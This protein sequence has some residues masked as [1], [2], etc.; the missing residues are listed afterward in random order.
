MKAALMAEFIVSIERRIIHEVRVTADS[1]AKARAEV[2]GYG[3]QEAW[4]D[5]PCAQESEVIRITGV[6]RA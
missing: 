1:P 3:E 4:S 6:K 2:I 5:Y